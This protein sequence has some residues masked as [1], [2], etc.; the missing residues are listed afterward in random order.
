M[1]GAMRSWDDHLTVEGMA[2]VGRKL[3]H[4]RAQLLPLEPENMDVRIL[5][6][7]GRSQQSRANRKVAQEFEATQTS[8]FKMQP[9][10]AWNY[11]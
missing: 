3:L 8:V 9:F 11:T 5:K 10:H 6:V 4:C 1:H 2:K 7:N